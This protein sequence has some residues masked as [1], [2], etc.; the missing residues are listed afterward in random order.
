M[1][2]VKLARPFISVV[3]CFIVKEYRVR[4]L[5]GRTKSIVED[6]D[7]LAAAERNVRRLEKLIEYVSSL[8]E[9]DLTKAWPEILKMYRALEPHTVPATV[10]AALRHDQHL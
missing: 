2:L 5:G 10:I 3:F 6:V 9:D 8:N 1:S 4:R 7:R